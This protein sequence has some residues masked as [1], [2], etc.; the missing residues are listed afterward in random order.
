MSVGPHLLLVEDDV[1][2]VELIVTGLRRK[3]LANHIDVVADGA[4]ALDY[5]F[6]RGDYATREAINPVLIL[7]DLKMPKVDGHE[8]L[9]QIKA[10]PLLRRIPVVVLTSSAHDRDVAQGYDLGANAYVVKPVEF[11]AFSAMVAQ[12]GLFWLLV[13]HP[14]ASG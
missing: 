14:P 13:N 3:Q 9:R 8:V 11:G 12:I 6:R 7:L 10:E 2:D 5:L 4:A 1:D